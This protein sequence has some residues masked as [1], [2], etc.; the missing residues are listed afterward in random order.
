MAKRFD[1]W[2]LT[3]SS[4]EGQEPISCRILVFE[5]VSKKLLNTAS[6]DTHMC[7]GVMLFNSHTVVKKLHP[8]P[9]LRGPHEPQ[10]LF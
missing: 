6:L 9:V 5:A 4:Y 2:I 8:N 1:P 10:G 7:S 3:F